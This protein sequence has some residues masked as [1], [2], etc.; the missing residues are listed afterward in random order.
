MANRHRYSRALAAALGLAVVAVTATHLSALAQRQQP[1]AAMAGHVMT[2]AAMKAWVDGWFAAHPAHGAAP[3]SVSAAPAD[4]FLTNNY[5]FDTDGSTL[6]QV[7]TAKIIQ[8]QTV[9]FKLVGGFHTT[10]SGNPGETTAGSHWDLPVDPSHLQQVVAFDTVG[11]FPFFCRP[12]G[13]AFNMRGVVIVSPNP[14]GVAPEPSAGGRVGF[15]APAWPNPT[16]T[17]ARFRFALARGGL[18]H[19]RIVDVSGRAVAT[20][21]DRELAAGTYQ[22]EWDG[23]SAGGAAAAGVY[24][25][26]LEAPGLRASTRLTISR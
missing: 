7:D 6:T 2:D 22:G 3:A 1:A 10:T 14:A 17:G 16:A 4:T 19:L 25:A 13:S 15:V 26:Q 24:F 11:R 20:V 5:Y 9:L 12:H 18:V 8:G 23:R 21:F